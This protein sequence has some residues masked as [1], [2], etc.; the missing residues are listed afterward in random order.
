[1]E[2]LERYRPGGYHP[3]EISHCL[4]ERYRIVHKLGHGTF[5]TIWLARDEQASKYVAVKVCTADAIQQEAHTLSRLREIALQKGAVGTNLVPAILDRFEVQG[6]NGIHSCFVTAPARCSLADMREGSAWC[7]QLDI[8]RSL[9]AQL[10]LAIAY[11]HHQGL[12]HGG[13]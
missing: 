1:V 8:A 5:S 2:R 13:E 3:I 4:H 9:A 12:V 7:F 10:A 6:P 11:I